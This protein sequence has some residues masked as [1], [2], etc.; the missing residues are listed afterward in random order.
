MIQNITRQLA[1]S[2]SKTEKEEIVRTVD[3]ELSKNEGTQEFFDAIKELKTVC[4]QK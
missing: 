2:Y 4:Q 1:P 3:R